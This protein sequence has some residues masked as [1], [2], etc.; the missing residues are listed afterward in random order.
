MLLDEPD[1][2]LHATLDGFFFVV[3]LQLD[4]D[5]HICYLLR[6]DDELFTLYTFKI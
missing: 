1:R 2:Q 3:L 6:L 4:R 5:L